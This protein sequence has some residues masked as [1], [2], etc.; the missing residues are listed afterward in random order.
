MDLS[1]GAR[2]CWRI[3]DA[4]PEGHAYPSHYYLAEKLR[5][6]RSAVRRYLRELKEAGFIQI[7]PRYDDENPQ[8]RAVRKSD[9]P[10][11]QTSNLYVVLNPADLV[12]CAQQI[13]QDW[14]A[15][16]QRVKV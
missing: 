9:R 2:E 4:F 12:A 10:R 7:R 14:T 13:I 15:K 3:L 5:M 11:G 1:F 8:P 6:S 16:R